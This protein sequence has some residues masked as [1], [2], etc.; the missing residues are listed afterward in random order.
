MNNQQQPLVSCIMPTYNRRKF[1]PFAL[2]YFMRQ[3]HEHKELIIIDDGTDPIIDLIPQEPSI[4]YFRLK[5]RLTLGDKLNLACD[6]AKGGIIVNW[7][8][9][10]W[11]DS[12]RIAYQI[13]TLQNEDMDVCG[14]NHLLYLDLN[15]KAAF[16][17]IYPPDQR[18]WLLGSSLCYTKS[19][20]KQ[21]PFASINVGMDALFVWSTPS[22][23]VKN[24]SNKNISVHMIH[25]DNVSPKKTEGSWWY[26][27]PIEEIQKI[28]K[29]DWNTY[30]NGKFSSPEIAIKEKN[31]TVSSHTT[32]SPAKPLKNIYACPV[33]EKEDCI[34]DLVRNLHYQD[35]D[36]QI[37]LYNGGENQKL[38]SSGFPYEKFGA[39]IY[40]EPVPLQYGYLHPFGLKCMEFALRNYSFDT[41]TIVDSDQLAIKKGYSKFLQDYLNSRSNIGLLSNK[42]E[43]ITSQNTEVWTATQAFKE[44]DLW[45]PLLKQFTNGE[46]KFVHWSFWPSTVFT[47]DAIKDLLNLF[48]DNRL[49]QEIMKKTQIWA[50]EEIVFP[51]LISLLGYEIAQNPCSQDFVSYRKPFTLK[52]L[53]D[54]EKTVSAFW[55]HPINREYDDALRKHTRQQSH[56]YIDPRKELETPETVDLLMMLP[57]L[58]SVN[59]I[60]GWLADKEADLLMAVTLKACCSLPTPHHIVEI[61]SYQ[62]KSTVV[63]GS[64]AKALFPDA[65][66]F[67]IDPHEGVVGATDQ[68]IQKVPPTLEKFKRNIHVAGLAKNVVLIK[69]YSFL[70][71]WQDPIVFLFID[72]LHDYPNVARDFW[73]FS[74]HVVPGGYIA[75]HDY[76]DYYPGVK[77]LVD[78]ILLSGNFKKVSLVESL[79]VIQKL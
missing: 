20:W 47:S 60:E 77:A 15:T 42:P 64:V 46:S 48:K 43:R 26:K 5:R 7:D 21:N 11:Y 45:K 61:G 25:E 73:K 52:D 50:T 28:M 23:R 2:R 35:P 53:Q 76:A 65:R 49:L 78:E 18:T 31:P 63:L 40:P 30:S 29:E 12:S 68:G 62:G 39:I 14:I 71:D 34:I 67:A 4:R 22:Q 6:Y 54:A 33:H 55:M 56:H 38:L 69:D 27:Y 58:E 79:M 13:K 32:P 37:L 9:D 75:F 17:Y 74:P 8:D 41:L 36:S 70:I 51:T 3:T 72:G 24:L 10:D 19:L 57:L 59:K 16:Q 1:I 44:Y 66:I